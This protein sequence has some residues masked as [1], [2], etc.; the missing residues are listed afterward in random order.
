[1][2]GKFPWF[3]ARLLYE[4]CIEDEGPSL[5]E[6]RIVVLR[7]NNGVEAAEK[8]A[9]KL[10]KAASDEYQNGAGESVAWRFKEVLEVVQLNQSSIEDG[11]EVYHHYLNADEVEN[12][13]Q[14]LKSG[15]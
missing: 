8:K 7:S 2:S 1:M 10:G 5:F 15:L 11:T 12:M 14:S 4:A 6:E 9:Q 13:R 3:A